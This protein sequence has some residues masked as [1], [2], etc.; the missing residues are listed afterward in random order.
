MRLRT[1]RADQPEHLAGR[2]GRDAAFG[3]HAQLRSEQLDV[4][5]QRRMQSGRGKMFGRD[6]GTQQIAVAPQHVAITRECRFIAVADHTERRV[7]A[8]VAGHRLA[9]RGQRLGWSALDCQQHETRDN[10]L[11]EL[12]DQNLLRRLGRAWQKRRHVGAERCS[13]DH[14]T[15]DEQPHDPEGDDDTAARHHLAAIIAGQA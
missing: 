5:L 14:R 6:G 4:R 15:G 9:E 2:V 3:E 1:E 11:A 7:H 10:S 12:I 8:Q 13:H